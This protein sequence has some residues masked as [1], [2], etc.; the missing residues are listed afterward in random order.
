MIDR[1]M[2]EKSRKKREACEKQVESS[3]AQLLKIS[4]KTAGLKSRLLQSASEWM[5]DGE[6]LF[7]EGDFWKK[8]EAIFEN[9]RECFLEAEGQWKKFSEEA[10]QFKKNTEKIRELEKAVP[11]LRRTIWKMYGVRQLWKQ[12]S[13]VNR[14][15]AGRF[16]KSCISYRRR[17][18][19]ASGSSLRRRGYLWK[20][21]LK[22]SKKTLK[23]SEAAGN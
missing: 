19:K 2:V 3:R 10:D 8:G 1:A 23:K 18:Q 16:G 4:E 13:R 11:G 22:K 21:G 5:E 12:K 20:P 7:E 6:A 9:I 17:K 14:S 15:G